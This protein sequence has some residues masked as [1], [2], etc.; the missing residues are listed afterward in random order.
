MDG[1]AAVDYE[2]AR[3][4]LQRGIAALYLVAFVSTLNQFRPLLGERGFLSAPELLD[5]A[6]SSPRARR[7]LRPT[8]FRWVRYTDRRLVALCVAGIVVS[9]ALVGGIPSEFWTQPWTLKSL[10]TS[11]GRALIEEGIREMK[12]LLREGGEPPADAVR[13]VRLFSPAG[14]VD[15]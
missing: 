9:A 2:F 8:L 6:R 7:L 5:W 3:Q 15:D 12:R 14:N 1:F 10:D 11:A 13:R 4:A